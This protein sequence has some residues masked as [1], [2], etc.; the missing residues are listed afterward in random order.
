MQ[1]VIKEKCEK[2]DNPLELN[3]KLRQ[4]KGD[5]LSDPTLYRCLA[6]SLVYLTS[7]RHD[8]SNAIN[9]VS[10][11]MT[12]PGNRHLAAVKRILRYILGTPTRAFFFSVES[13]MTLTA[14]SDAHWA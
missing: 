7:T 3:V 13:P 6:G 8:T 1:P 2:A 14:Y 12:N 10:Q 5:P 11:F 9:L 4:N